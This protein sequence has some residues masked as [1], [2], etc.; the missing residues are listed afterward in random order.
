MITIIYS[1]I[2]EEEDWGGGT[3]EWATDSNKDIDLDLML[4]MRDM[5][6]QSTSTNNKQ[7]SS[8]K[9]QGNVKIY[10]VS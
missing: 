9:K 10:L 2:E 7:Q 5:S 8:S 1:S 6:L 4:K 3:D